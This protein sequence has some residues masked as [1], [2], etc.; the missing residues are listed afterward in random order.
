MT[1]YEHGNIIMFLIFFSFSIISFFYIFNN[2]GNGKK[3]EVKQNSKE[4]RIKKKINSGSK[5]INEN[6]KK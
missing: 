3:K 5:A 4:K 6:K 1:F 2:K